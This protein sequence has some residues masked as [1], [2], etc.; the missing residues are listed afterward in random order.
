MMDIATGRQPNR[1]GDNEIVSN[2]G[3]ICLC[4]CRQPNREIRW[5]KNKEQSEKL[6]KHK[7]MLSI[8]VYNRSIVF[9]L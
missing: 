9:C 6:E 8:L 5:K 3:R 7:A 2:H 1:E 4:T